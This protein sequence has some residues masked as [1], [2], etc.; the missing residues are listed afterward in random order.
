MS[1]TTP[2][3]PQSRLDSPRFTDRWTPNPRSSR[4][5]RFSA[6]RRSWDR[7]ASLG[8]AGGHA[9]FA[10]P[11]RRNIFDA[12]GRARPERTALSRRNFV[13]EDPAMVRQ[14]ATW[15][16]GDVHTIHDH[17]GVGAGVSLAEM[18]VSHG[19]DSIWSL[20]GPQWRRPPLALPPRPKYLTCSRRC[21]G[22]YARFMVQKLEALG[23]TRG[24]PASLVIV[25][26]MRSFIHRHIRSGVLPANMT[27]A[28]HSLNV[29]S[30]ARMFG[31]MSNSLSFA[32]PNN[33]AD[34][35]EAFRAHARAAGC[36]FESLRLAPVQYDLSR[37]DDCLSLIH[38]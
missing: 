25:C 16:T 30:F 19:N 34:M 18:V 26:N 38:I 35:L 22:T 29:V 13:R 36:T 31:V 27:D 33:K 9:R 2:R 12:E 7:G 24:T 28:K 15:L 10:S 17:C 21:A 32:W 6:L 11:S 3:Y 5:Q 1:T 4:F 37:T 8:S 14:V 23:W 20:A